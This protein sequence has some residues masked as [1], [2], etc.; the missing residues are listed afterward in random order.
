[1]YIETVLFFCVIAAV[2]GLFFT[3]ASKAAKR[4]V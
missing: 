2:F 3:F 4:K 1:M